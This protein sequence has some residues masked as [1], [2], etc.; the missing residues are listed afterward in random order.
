VLAAKEARSHDRSQQLA[1]LFERHADFVWRTLCRLG[2]SDDQADDAA[3]EVFLV[4][5]RKLDDLRTV[6]EARPWLFAICRRVASTHRRRRDRTKTGLSQ[7][8]LVGVGEN[9]EEQTARR[10]AI[11]LIETFVESLDEERR[12]PFV[13]YELEGLT[14]REIAEATGWKLNTVFTRLKAARRRFES[15][16]AEVS[17]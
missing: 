3:Q 5:H 15:Y 8:P 14:G 2:L 7:V 9:P 13:L 1:Q 17:K 12:I 10:S 11:R 6:E 16:V 4:V